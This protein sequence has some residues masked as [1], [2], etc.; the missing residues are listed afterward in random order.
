MPL[1]WFFLMVIYLWDEK[2]ENRIAVQ[3]MPENSL[4]KES[5]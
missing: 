1:G 4:P 2:S 5:I 3:Y